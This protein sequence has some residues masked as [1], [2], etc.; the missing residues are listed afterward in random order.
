VARTLLLLLMEASLELFF[1]NDSE[2][3][4]R[5][6]SDAVLIDNCPLLNSAFSLRKRK[7]SQM[8]KSHLLF[9]N[10]QRPFYYCYS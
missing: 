6:L 2:F 9:E 7:K 3:R 4:R 5:V 1:R 10:V 8:K